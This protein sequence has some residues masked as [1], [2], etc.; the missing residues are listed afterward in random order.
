MGEQ[1]KRRTRLRLFI[2]PIPAVDETSGAR[3]SLRGSIMK[4]KILVII[5][6]L[7]VAAFGIGANSQSDS[8]PDGIPANRWVEIGNNAGLVV[9]NEVKGPRGEVT[10]VGAQLYLK[11][12]NGWRKS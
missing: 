5:G 10:G 9:K 3:V 2:G 1:T 11:T 12:Q 4:S 6:T 8:R 7:L